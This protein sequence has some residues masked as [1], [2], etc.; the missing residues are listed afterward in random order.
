[1][2]FAP[3]GRTALVTRDGDHTL[4]L[5]TIE[6]SSVAPAGRDFAAGLRPYDADLT[7]DGRIAVV[8]NLGRGQGDADTVSVIDLQ[9]KPPRVVETVTVGPTPEGLA[10]SP[11]GKTVAVVIQDGSNKARESPF[12]HP[13]GQLLL[14]R[15]DGFRLTKFAQAP[16]GRW[17]QG[18]AFS[19]D[20]RTILVQNMLEK[21]IQVFR[22]DG[23]TLRDTGQRIP[24][25]GGGA[26]LRTAKF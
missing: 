12:Y 14:L 25:G 23:V 4:S 7:N 21:D 8:A 20:G 9:A 6:G 16:V 22:V 18:V 1:M 15:L 11:D 10:L 13:N 24:L 26:A 3:D 19:K 5:L 2:V 17:S